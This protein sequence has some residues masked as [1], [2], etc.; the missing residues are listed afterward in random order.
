MLE[1]VR[2]LSCGVVSRCGN[3][4]DT[5]KS[6]KKSCGRMVS[7]LEEDERVGRMGG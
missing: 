2:R 6:C 5:M 3:G 1:E 7:R 4:F